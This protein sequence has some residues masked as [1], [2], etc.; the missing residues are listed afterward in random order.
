[1]KLFNTFKLLVE[2]YALCLVFILVSLNHFYGPY[3][4]HIFD[5]S[6]NSRK[7]LN[8]IA[9]TII[10]LRILLLFTKCTL[11]WVSVKNYHIFDKKTRIVGLITIIG[12]A[13]LILPDFLMSFYWYYYTD[14][15]LARIMIY[16]IPFLLGFY[17]LF[18]TR[19]K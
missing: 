12:Y 19:V 11:N 6:L 3:S 9:A 7:V 8:L 15:Y 1:M 16:P 18:F 13:I 5:F 10:L 17:T 4:E 14:L 2:I